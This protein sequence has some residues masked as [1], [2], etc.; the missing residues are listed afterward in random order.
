MRIAVY[1]LKLNIMSA[2]HISTMILPV[3]PNSLILRHQVGRIVVYLNYHNLDIAN[4]PLNNATVR[5]K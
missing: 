4:T 2:V 5:E 3:E 1:K